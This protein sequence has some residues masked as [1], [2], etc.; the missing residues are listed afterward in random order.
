[1]KGWKNEKRSV[2][3]RHRR[4]MTAQTPADNAVN[5]AP[6]RRNRKTMAPQSQGRYGANRKPPTSRRK[7]LPPGAAVYGRVESSA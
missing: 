5:A 3:G 4:I 2:C 7:G 6:L 1:M